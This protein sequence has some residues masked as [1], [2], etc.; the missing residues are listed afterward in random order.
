MTIFCLL[1]LWFFSSSLPQND[2]G[3]L[4]IIRLLPFSYAFRINFFFRLKD[5]IRTDLLFNVQRAI[6][7]CK[8]SPYVWRICFFFCVHPTLCHRCRR[9]HAI[10]IEHETWISTTFLHMKYLSKCPHSIDNVC[11]LPTTQSMQQYRTPS[12]EKW[13]ENIDSWRHS[14]DNGTNRRREKKHQKRRGVE[15][16]W[17]PEMDFQI[18]SKFVCF[19]DICDFPIYFCV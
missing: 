3:F 18:D 1:L 9:R 8:I 6:Y 16:R 4:F 14:R 2:E 15:K 13:L 5:E 17:K 11:W 12:N 19:A 10:V 7:S